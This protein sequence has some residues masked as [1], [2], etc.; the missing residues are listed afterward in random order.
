[1]A[2][3]PLTPPARAR[4]VRR[5]WTTRGAAMSVSGRPFR[6]RR[7]RKPGRERFSAARIATGQCG[8]EAP[9]RRLRV[10]RRRLE[11]PALQA[12][13]LRGGVEPQRTEILQC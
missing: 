8:E 2:A 12:R 11:S 7:N 1:M 4:I 5:S 10:S 9:A 13:R 6:G 3:E